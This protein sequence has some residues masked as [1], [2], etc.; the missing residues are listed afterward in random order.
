MVGEEFYISLTQDAKPFCVGTPCTITFIYQ[1]KLKTELDVLLRQKIIAP[2]TAIADITTAN[3]RYV[4]VIDAMT[5]YHQCPLDSDSQLSLPPLVD[6]SSYGSLMASP[7]SKN[8]TIVVWQ[9]C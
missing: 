6:S 5:G 4:T 3:A 7:P 8:T 9:K 2:V 1:D